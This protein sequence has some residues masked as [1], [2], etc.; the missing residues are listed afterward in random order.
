MAALLLAITDAAE[1]GRVLVVLDASSP[2]RAWLRFR[3]S[4]NR[5]KLDYYAARL[6][7]SLDQALQKIAVVVFFWQTS[8]VGS[9]TNEW[10]DL[11]ATAA[12]C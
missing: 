1:G 6:L 2:V 10:A 9:P 12:S 7:D 11:S 4:H 5:H 3:G 8:H